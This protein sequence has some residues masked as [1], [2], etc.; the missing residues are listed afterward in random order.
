MD[1]PILFASGRDGWAV[2][3]LKDERINIEPLFK[4]IIEHV[5]APESDLNGP[6]KMLVTTL[7]MDPFVGR[8]LTGRITSGSVKTNQMIK[9][10]SRDGK[11]D[12][13]I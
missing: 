4:K 7:H 5:P 2:E 10:L 6:F 9:A 3:N 8:V 11:Y 1:Y 13:F 12:A